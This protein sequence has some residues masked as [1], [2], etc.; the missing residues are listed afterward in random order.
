MDTKNYIKYKAK[1]SGFMPECEGYMRIGEFSKRVGLAVSTV[2]KYE[3]Q[4][5]IISHHKSR[6]SGHRYYTQE[7][8]DDYMYQVSST[9]YKIAERGLNNG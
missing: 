3:K 1:E 5:L 4:G 2:K 8:A 6:L 7:Q 9:K